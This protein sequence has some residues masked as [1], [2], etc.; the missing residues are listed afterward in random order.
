MLG[1]LLSYLEGFCPKFKQTYGQNF[2]CAH[3]LIPV[4]IM[5]SSGYFLLQVINLFTEKKGSFDRKFAP[6]YD[7]E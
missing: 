1:S 4:E 7:Q 2:A 3:F 5:T 6:Y